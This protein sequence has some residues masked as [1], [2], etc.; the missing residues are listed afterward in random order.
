M[1]AHS[2]GIEDEPADESDG[3]AASGG[4]LTV[5]LTALRANYARLRQEA[6]GAE[7][8]G[9][10]KANAYGLGI[11]PVAKALWAEGCRTFFVAQLCE[12]LELRPLLPDA[13]IFVLNGLASGTE[14]AA[15]RRNIRPVLNSLPQIR[16]WSALAA[17]EGGRL[18][19]AIQVDSGMSRLGLSGQEVEAVAADSALLAGIET[20]LVMSHLACAD[21]P[22][23][24]ANKAQLESFRRL[25]ALLPKAP[26]SLAN[27]AGV[28]LGPDFRFDLVR[29]GIAL[30]GGRPLAGER[31]N[32]MRPVVRLEARIVQLRH[33]PAGAGIGY[34]LSAVAEQAMRLA[35]IGIGYADG[36]PRRLGNHIAAFA[37]ARALPMV[38]RVSMDSIILDIGDA[39]LGDGDLVDL[40]GQNQDVDA[41]AGAAD[42]ISYEILT[43]LG[44]R[45][46]RRYIGESA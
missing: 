45:F 40:I 6:T 25:A 27:S 33:V 34:G 19:A 46:A 4:I 28:F 39:P 2:N 10:V 30:Y 35:T 3:F 8:A 42:T 20:R 9:V 14:E 31:A 15:A 24:P 5:D 7:V 21:E 18:P 17:R 13:D 11:E 37:G 38:G 16:A 44:R 43:S 41:V 26:L 36:W 22:A 1:L 32:P 29:P 12:A 23:H